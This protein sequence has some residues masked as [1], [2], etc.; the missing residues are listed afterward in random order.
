MSAR[1]GILVPKRPGSAVRIPSFPS[2]IFVFLGGIYACGLKLLKIYLKT[3]FTVLQNGIES[4]IW[5]G[6][7]PLRETTRKESTMSPGIL[8]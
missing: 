7:I 8:E 1:P 3:Y 4:R 2:V 6:K 5:L